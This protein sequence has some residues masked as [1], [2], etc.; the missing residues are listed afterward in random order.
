M[1]GEFSEIVLFHGIFNLAKSNLTTEEINNFF[2]QIIKE[3]R[4]FMW[5]G[6]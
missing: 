1:A 5:Q 6:S 3:G 2:R 4:S